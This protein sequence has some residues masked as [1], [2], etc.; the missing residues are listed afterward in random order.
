LQIHFTHS[1]KIAI[2]ILSLV[3]L[4]AYPLRG[5]CAPSE[6]G[7]VPVSQAGQ[8]RA[9]IVLPMSPGESTT[10]AAKELQGYLRALSGAEVPIVSEDGV[11]SNAQDKSWI[12]VGGPDQNRLVK[13]AVNAGLNGFSDLKNDGFV[14]KTFHLGKRPVVVAGGDNDT[15]TMYAIFDLA[16]QLGVTFRLSGDILPERQSSLSVPALNLREEPAIQQR[17]F[18]SEAHRANV[19][20]LSTEDWS[21]LFDQMAKMKYNYYEFWWFAYEPYVQYSYRGES[22]LLGDISTKASGYVNTMYEGLGSRTTNDVVIGK[23]WFPGERLASPEMQ[24]VETPDQAF[25]VAQGQLQHMIH[26]A[27]SRH[28]DMWLVDEMGCLPPNLARFTEPVGPRP[29]EGIWGPFVDPLDPINREIQASRL[30]AM[31]DTYPE[32]AGYLLNFPE[33]YVGLKSAKDLEFFAQP[34]QQVMFHELRNLM[35]PWE[36]RWQGDRDVMVNSDLGFYDQFKY[37]L[38]KK[39]EFAPNAKV[40]LS[41]LGRGYILPM[42]DKMLPKGIPFAT[43]DTGEACGYGTAN[44]PMH[45]F[46]GMG[47]R[48]RI[49]SPYLDDDCDIVAQQFNVWVYTDKDRIFSDGVKNGL[50]GLAPW[51]SR[52]RGTETNSG[53]LAKADWN[54]KLTREEFYKDYSQRLFGSGAEPDIYSA[55]MTLEKN[56]AYL[57]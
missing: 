57:D 2:S 41:T 54:P 25:T 6:A 37:L 23:Q 42:Y 30:K 14:L 3:S 33:Y 16:E 43:A 44:M 34:Q 20:I 45:Y 29:I 39:N 13:Q 52:P 49:D 4:F 12:L 15:G 51:M 19:A 28:I 5:T 36:T 11:S 40:G 10:W 7:A 35:V 48:A 24:H 17:G 46:G 27:K 56:K 47:Q 18:L 53:F 22:V 26:Y 8:P 50:T 38:A 9:V 21:K 32:A 55:F 1:C 31:I